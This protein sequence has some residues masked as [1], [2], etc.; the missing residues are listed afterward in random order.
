VPLKYLERE[1]M[2]SQP[3]HALLASTIDTN[4]SSALYTLASEIKLARI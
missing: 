1:V 2:Q 4:S 3:S